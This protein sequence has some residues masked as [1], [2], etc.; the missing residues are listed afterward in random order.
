[1][2]TKE[3]MICIGCGKCCQVVTFTINYTVKKQ[4]DE[5]VEFY[6]ARGFRVKT[7]KDCIEV[8]IPTVCPNL[9]KYGCSTYGSRPE[10]CKKYDG[11][12]DPIIKD[13]CKLPPKEKNH[14]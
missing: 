8:I 11:R 14:D 9:T 3:E 12:D 2:I 4:C 5:M 6:K 10:L 1:M 13:V 7:H